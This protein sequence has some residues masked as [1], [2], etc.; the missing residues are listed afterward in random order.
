MFGF[1][2]EFLPFKN[3]HP[4][5]VFD[6]DGKV[7]N[8]KNP[9]CYLYP[10]ENDCEPGGHFRL[11]QPDELKAFTSYSSFSYRK[12][13][14]QQATDWLSLLTMTAVVAIALSYLLVEL[15]S[16]RVLARR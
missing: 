8:F 9:A 1:R 10:A 2:L 15:R 12:S 14:I 3:I 11:D 13:A 5:P 16:Y 4:G 6:N 7:Y